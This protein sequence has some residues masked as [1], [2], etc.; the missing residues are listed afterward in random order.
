MKKDQ[1]TYLLGGLAVVIALVVAFFVGVHVGQNRLVRFGNTNMPM[2]Q[3]TW[4][5]PVMVRGMMGNSGFAMRPG[6]QG[7]SMGVVQTVSGN[8]L[9]VKFLNGVS[10]TMTVSTTATVTKTSQVN[11]GSITAGDNV[12]FSGQNVNG[13][14][15]VTSVRII[16][17]PTA[18]PAATPT[19]AAQ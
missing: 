2:M 15:T 5:R 13:T 8:Q 1:G 6:M 3:R 7:D 17:S 11:V 10:Q 12:L 16:P 4:G 14:Y 19:A 18:T 9:T